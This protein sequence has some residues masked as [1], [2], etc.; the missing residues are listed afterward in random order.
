LLKAHIPSVYTVNGQIAKILVFD[1]LFFDYAYQFLTFG[2]GMTAMWGVER[3]RHCHYDPEGHVLSPVAA[4]EN[5]LG[6]KICFH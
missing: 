4:C 2:D 6:L 5:G 3:C 1:R